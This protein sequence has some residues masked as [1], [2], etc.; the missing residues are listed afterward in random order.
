MLF[1]KHKNRLYRLG[2]LLIEEAGGIL[3]IDAVVLKL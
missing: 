2:V 1:G 3:N